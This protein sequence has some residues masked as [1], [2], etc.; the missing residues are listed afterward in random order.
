M[1]QRID[2]TDNVRFSCRLDLLGLVYMG[3]SS[4]H[5]VVPSKMV[6][7]NHPNLEGIGLELNATCLG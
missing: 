3:N 7:E 6:S 2:C 1:E 4:S 5:P